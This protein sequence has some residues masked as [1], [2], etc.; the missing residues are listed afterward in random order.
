MLKKMKLDIQNSI[1]K[2]LSKANKNYKSKSISAHEIILSESTFPNT[3]RDKEELNYNYNNIL[4]TVNLLLSNENTNQKTN[5]QFNK[6]ANSTK[7]Q[8]HS[9]NRHSKFDQQKSD[10]KIRLYSPSQN[11]LNFSASTNYNSPKHG[12][13][14]SI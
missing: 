12:Q 1:K 2:D 4:E 14:S 5:H 8:N 11:E 3:L 13:S 6:T 7:N 10:S 9:V